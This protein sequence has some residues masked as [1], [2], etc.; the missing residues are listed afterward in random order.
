MTD[1]RQEKERKPIDPVITWAG[2]YC[3]RCLLCVSI[4]P[5]KNLRFEGE[6][7]VSEGKCIQC[8]LCQKYCPD[9]TIEVK[10][11]KPGAEKEPEPDKER[12]REDETAGHGK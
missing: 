11:K 8:Q 2:D 5:V 10:P 3:K 12:K 4:C 1:R 9:F 7:M 6:E